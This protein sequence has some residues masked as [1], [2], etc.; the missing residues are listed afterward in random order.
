MSKT[1]LEGRQGVILVLK[2][3]SFRKEEWPCDLDLMIY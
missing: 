3:F 1:Y 2:Q